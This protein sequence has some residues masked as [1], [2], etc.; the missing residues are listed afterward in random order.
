[1]AGEIR[2]ATLEVIEEAGHLSTL[3]APEQVNRAL[4]SWLNS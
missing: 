2:H 4:D 1:M 3:D